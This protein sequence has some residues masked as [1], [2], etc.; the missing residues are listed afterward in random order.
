MGLAET[1]NPLL[2]QHTGQRCTSHTLYQDQTAAPWLYV[3]E[4]VPALLTNCYR[5]SRFCMFAEGESDA[6]HLFNISLAGFLN[7]IGVNQHLA[8]LLPTGLGCSSSWLFISSPAAEKN[9]KKKRQF[10]PSISAVFVF[11][12]TGEKSYSLLFLNIQLCALR[13]TTYFSI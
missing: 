13:F 6:I 11:V 10:R 7:M 12:F 8:L 2:Q 9:K 4:V 1:V 5:S 3:N